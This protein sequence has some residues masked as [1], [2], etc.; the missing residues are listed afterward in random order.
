MGQAIDNIQS[1][2]SDEEWNLLCCSPISIFC[3]IAGAD[4]NIDKK[5]FL[6]FA[7][8]LM[9]LKHYDHDLINGV[10][11]G[12]VDNIE[13]KFNQVIKNLDLIIPN[14]K[15]IRTT[16]KGKVED[17]IADEFCKSLLFVGVKVASATGGILGFGSKI[18]KVEKEMLVRIST[19][20]DL[21]GNLEA[22][23]KG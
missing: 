23:I 2:F 11:K 7:K 19:M 18:S 10:Y 8:M 21:E 5:E 4:G 20:L 9:G 14:V 1:K 6:A 12:T 13:D 15:K 3:L 17:K 16:L 22:Y